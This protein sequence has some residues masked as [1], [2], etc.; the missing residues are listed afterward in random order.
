MHMDV[1]VKS[2]TDRSITR[3][4]A[5]GSIKEIMINEDFLMHSKESISLCFK[6]KDSSGIITLSPKE[7]DIIVKALR[8]KRHLVKEVKIYK[9]DGI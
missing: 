6:G 7:I 4:H 1:K 8:K 5:K 2:Q 9:G 3:L